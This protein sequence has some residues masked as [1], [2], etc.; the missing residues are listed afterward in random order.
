M[1]IYSKLRIKSDIICIPSDCGDSTKE[2][3]I[4][5]NVAQMFPEVSRRILIFES[6]FRRRMQ[7]YFLSVCFVAWNRFSIFCDTDFIINGVMEE[8]NIS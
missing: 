7:L 5:Q 3:I 2:K 1:N 8:V 6:S 4:L